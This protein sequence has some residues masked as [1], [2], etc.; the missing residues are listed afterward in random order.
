MEK[1]KGIIRYLLFFILNSLTG[2]CSIDVFNVPA[3]S[4][5]LFTDGDHQGKH[6]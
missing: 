2:I 1:I 4:L 6:L 5:I 3:R